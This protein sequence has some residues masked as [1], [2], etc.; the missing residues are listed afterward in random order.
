MDTAGDFPSMRREAVHALTDLNEAINATYGITA[1]ERFDYDPRAG[2]LIFSH[3]G[4]PRVVA[5]KS[6][7]RI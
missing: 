7:R 2:T 1:R 3:R 4:G 5:G 6:G